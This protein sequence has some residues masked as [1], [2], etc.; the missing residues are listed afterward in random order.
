LIWKINRWKQKKYFKNSIFF[1]KEFLFGFNIF[2]LT[3]KFINVWKFKVL[4]ICLN[5]IFQ[6]LV[7]LKF[8]LMNLLFT[9]F[10]IQWLLLG[11][12]SSLRLEI[13]KFIIFVWIF[14]K[15]FKN[16]K[17][18]TKEKKFFNEIYKSFK[19]FVFFKLKT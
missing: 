2:S 5:F 11:G 13:F 7:N 8:Q 4:W 14:H 1:Q 9:I 3:L 17:D 12:S 10:A 19:S 16:V 15:K 18:W 6:S